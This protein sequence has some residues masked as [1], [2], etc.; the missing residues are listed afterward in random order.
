MG[1]PVFVS[2]A[3]LIPCQEDYVDPRTSGVKVSILVSLPS[4]VTRTFD[5]FGIF[6]FGVMNLLEIDDFLE[7]NGFPK[8]APN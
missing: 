6:G 1:F 8:T 7:I 5:S 3:N 4:L 2:F